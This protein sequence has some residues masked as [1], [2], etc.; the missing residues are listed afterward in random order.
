MWVRLLPEW[1]PNRSR[2]QRNVYHRFTVDRHLLEASAEAARLTQRVARPD[3]LVVGALLHDVGKGYP[4]DHTEVGMRLVGPMVQR[5]GFSADDAE[6][7]ARLVEHHLLLP[8]V[9][10]RRD[11]ED[12]QTLSAVAESVRTVEFLELLA[13]LTEADS[14]A[15]GPTAWGGWKAQLV[16]TLTE[17]TAHY[18]S[19]ERPTATRRS[20]LTDRLESLMSAGEMHV[21]GEGDRLT[22]IAPDQAGLFSRAAGALALRGLDVLQADAYSSEAGMALA[23]FRVAMP[24]V[25][26]DWHRLT[27]DVKRA[28]KG[29]LAIDARIAERARVYRRRSALAAESAETQVLFD[30]ESATDATIVEVRTEDHIGVLY[31]VTR[32]LAEM[33]LDIRYAKIQTLAHEVVDSFYVAGPDGP[34]LDHLHQ[35]ELELALR[36][37]LSLSQSPL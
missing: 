17:A 15:T 36:H 28:V 14:L 1:A 8:D 16:E 12:E 10:T 22:V 37:G 30:T 6:T 4:G 11:L 13:A 7:V 35:R 23:I 9:A 25:P 31:Q 19:G 32:I 2:P 29:Y 21:E 34:I 33:G 24:D 18:M 5:C 20:I 26:I 27:H 3:L